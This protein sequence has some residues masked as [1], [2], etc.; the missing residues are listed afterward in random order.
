M[1]RQ[2]H[3]SPSFS[4]VSCFSSSLVLSSC[5][6]QQHLSKIGWSYLLLSPFAY[7][8]PLKYSVMSPFSW[9]MLRPL[10]GLCLLCIR[11]SCAASSVFPWC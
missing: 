2:W 3:L 4:S 7:L 6:L 5:F 1:L 11:P 10:Q 8:P 9:K